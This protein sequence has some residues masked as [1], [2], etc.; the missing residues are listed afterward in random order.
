MDARRLSNV[1]V[2][3]LPAVAPPAA[4]DDDEAACNAE[5]T[6][7]AAT[8]ALNGSAETESGD[9]DADVRF[10]ANALTATASVLAAAESGGDTTTG[11][12]AKPTAPSASTANT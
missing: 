7:A 12:D 9:S 6:E 4:T 3:P 1:A 11:T 5:A 10:A 2:D 8:R